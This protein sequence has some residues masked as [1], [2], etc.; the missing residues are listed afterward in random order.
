MGILCKIIFWGEMLTEIPIVVFFFVWNTFNKAPEDNTRD[1]NRR[2]PPS[3]RAQSG[4]LAAGNLDPLRARRRPG[5]V[6]IRRG[7]P[8]STSPFTLHLLR[9]FFCFSSVRCSFILLICMFFGTCGKVSAPG[10]VV[11]RTIVFHFLFASIFYR[12]FF[13][14]TCFFGCVVD[15][16]SYLFDLFV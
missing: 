2:T 14:F 12:F 6:S 10:L 7:L 15:V 13:I 1:P 9:S 4:T 11:V 3:L 5:R 16:F 8:F